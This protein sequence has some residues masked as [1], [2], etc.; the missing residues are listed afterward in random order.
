MLEKFVKYA[1]CQYSNNNFVGQFSRYKQRQI[2]NDCA[3]I[4][5]RGADE[6]FVLLECYAVNVGCCLPELRNN[7]PVPFCR[8]NQ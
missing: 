3:R 6:T 8:D 4:R 2:L 5:G 1:V 7:V